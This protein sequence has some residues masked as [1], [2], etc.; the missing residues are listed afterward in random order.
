MLL[1]ATGPG[2]WAQ[3]LLCPWGITKVQELNVG[4][5]P[6]GASP[7]S[8]LEPGRSLTLAERGGAGAEL[9][10][11]HPEFRIVA[12]MNP[13]E[14]GLKRERCGFRA[15]T[16]VSWSWGGE[17]LPDAT[18]SCLILG[19]H[20]SSAGSDIPP[21]HTRCLPG[22][23]AATMARRSCPLRCPTDSPPSGSPPS[24]TATSCGPSW[25][26][27]LRVGRARAAECKF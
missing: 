10:V 21:P 12:T 3:I 9:V 22:L 24:R 26:A 11:A 4:P 18:V 19:W 16:A 27:G 6:A 7:C 1:W 13:G 8:V 2:V 5:S 17:A 14:G 25:R 23:Q 15:C 20:R